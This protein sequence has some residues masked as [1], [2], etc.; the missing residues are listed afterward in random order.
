[1]IEITVYAD[2]VL[3]RLDQIPRRI[4]LALHEKFEQIFATL[5]AELFSKVPGKYL[6]PGFIQ[7]GV[8]DQGSLVIGFVEAQAKPGVYSIFP[9][10]ARLLKFVTK[11][12][13]LVFARQVT[14][15]PYLK[16]APMVERLLRESKPWI[17]AEL[18]AAV[19]EA[20]NV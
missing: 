19:V 15:H 20:L 8:E 7:S 17:L 18:D 10:K 11:E 14:R 5:R 3:F 2:E 6:D 4:R 9:S 1:V 13:Q 16:G 12:G